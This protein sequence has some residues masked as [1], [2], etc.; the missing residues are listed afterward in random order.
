VC[1]VSEEVKLKPPKDTYRS[2]ALRHPVSNQQQEVSSER[3]SADED[4]KAATTFLK[5]F[6]DWVSAF[7]NLHLETRKNFE[8]TNKELQLAFQKV[9]NIE[10]KCRSTE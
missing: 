4:L 3:S 6:G 8:D 2:A 9:E 5:H 7:L 10:I 1:L